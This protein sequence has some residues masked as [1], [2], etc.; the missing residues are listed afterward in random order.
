[1]ARDEISPTSSHSW[2]AFLI[3]AATAAGMA[4]VITF[5]SD[6]STRF[7]LLVFGCF[8]LTTGAALLGWALVRPPAAAA[9]TLML[10]QALTALLAA[11]AALQFYSSGAQLLAPLIAGW[12]L[13]TG[14]AELATGIRERRRRGQSRDEIFLG[15]ITLALAV[16]VLVVPTGY[17]QPWSGAGGESGVLSSSIVVV[18]ALGA[19]SAIAAVYMAIAGM[20]LKWAPVPEPAKE[21]SS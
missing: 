7:G 6:H 19:Y 8:A 13:V 3:R 12:A 15:A 17:A 21:S 4:A 18:G 20:S 5:S 14:A 10:V 1:M 11:V 9:R 16:A 2:A